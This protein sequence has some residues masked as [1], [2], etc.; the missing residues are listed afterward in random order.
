[1]LRIQKIGADGIQLHNIASW[2]G[3]DN[4]KLIGRLKEGQ[5][6]ELTALAGDRTANNVRTTLAN[7]IKSRGLTQVQAVIRGNRIF[8]VNWGNRSH[9]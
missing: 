2:V 4:W 6:V 3:N 1:M 8:I 5:M 7:G 9:S